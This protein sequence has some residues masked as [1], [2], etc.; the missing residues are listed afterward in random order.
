MMRNRR[1][2]SWLVAALLLCLCACQSAY[3]GALEKIGIAKRDLLL[4]RVD[5]A[6]RAQGEAEQAYVDALTRFRSV[7]AVEAGELEATYLRLKSAHDAA[8]ARAL[9]LD[10]RVAAV[11]A[12]AE[13]LF[14]EWEAE[15][16]QY[17][18]AGL[19]A[20][21]KA[22]LER[23]RSRYRTLDQ[24]M[25]RAAASFAPALK[26]LGDQVL[27]LKHNLNA[28]AIGAIKDELPRLQADAA[29]L[30][31]D[32]QRATAEADRFLRDFRVEAN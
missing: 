9:A 11:E 22:Q 29:G 2:W 27:Y 5:A 7:L 30:Q 17:G 20:K 18:D 16:A 32:V 13:A 8:A 31:R 3:F 24:A 14:A 1:G 23:T 4:D 12:V 28:A 10:E 26:L 19:R 15:L 25:H 21:S 6:R